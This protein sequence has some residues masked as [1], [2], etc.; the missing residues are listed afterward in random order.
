MDLIQL[1]ALAEVLAPICLIITI[2]FFLQRSSAKVDVTSIS[3]L[4]MLVGTPALVFSTL[5]TTDLPTQVLMDVS[6]AALCT[7]GLAIIFALICLKLIG[8]PVNT[9]LPPLTMPNS[10]NLGLP[11]VLLAFGADGLA[12]GV[13]FY[14]VV[15]IIQY[16]LMPIVVAGAFSP[17]SLVKEPLIWAVIAALFVK[18]TGAMVP[19][20]IAD[21][22]E[23]LGGMMIPV[24]LVLLGA[25]IAGLGVSDLK[26]AATLA[27]LRLGIGL[28]AG[29]CTIYILGA[30]GIAAG[31]IFILSSMPS[32]VVTY[33]IAAR[34]DQGPK[35][36]AG[37]VVMSTLLTLICLP[38]LLWV[39]LQLAA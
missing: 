16:T 10:G 15:A 4:I 38:L 37:L 33:V 35:R 30:T 22:T 26:T 3:R 13:A 39:S 27:L 20:I 11:L 36:V 5:T 34:Y 6:L 12:I 1:K 29:L 2:G 32:A 14:F 21:T 9:Y 8:K 25:A 19:L 18:F 7:C 31:A 24:M 23:I 17:K 28:A